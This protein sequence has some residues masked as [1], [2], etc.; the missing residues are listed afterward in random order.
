MT[1]LVTPFRNDAIDETAFQD[2]VEWQIAQGCAAL[3]PCGVTGEGPTL[4]TDEHCR[5]V[6]ATVEAAKG[7]VPVVAATG[8]NCT[9]STIVLTEA[10]R[11]SGADAALV[12]TPYYNKPGQEGLFRHYEAIA[13]AVDI[14]IVAQV[15]RSRANV[16]LDAETIARLAAIPSI[17]GISDA[18]MDATP[19]PALTSAGLMRFVANDL[20]AGPLSQSDPDGWISSVANVLPGLCRSAEAA[21]RNGDAA[22]ALELHRKLAPLCAALGREGAPAA[23]KYATSLLHPGFDPT[24]RLPITPI[25]HETAAMVRAALADLVE[26]AEPCPLHRHASTRN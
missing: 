2:F 4:S 7:R 8:T 18:A 22:R 17:V 24:P 1:D 20:F 23:V 19:S 13:R 14:P 6:R 11:R 12:V 10:A 16:A 3:A 15:D 26:F 9:A 21:R 5:L 25:S